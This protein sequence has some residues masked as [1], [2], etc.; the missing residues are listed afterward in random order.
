MRAFQILKTAFVFRNRA[1]NQAFKMSTEAASSATPTNPMEV[2]VKI[3][4]D[5]VWPFCFIGLRNLEAASKQSGVPTNLA[6]EP[7][8]LNPNMPPEGESIKEHMS[9]KYGPSAVKNLGD[10][11]SGLAR[12]GA[13]VGI[14]FN[15]ERNI[16]PTVQAHS[17]LE[18]VKN[19]LGD[20]KKANDM[21]EELYQRYFIQ[22]QNINSVPVL[23]EVC[24]MFGI[25]DKE[26]VKAVA[27]DPAR[28]QKVFDKDRL[29]KTRMNIHG[30]PFFIIEPNDGGTPT[31]FSGAQP[32]DLM[33]EYLREAAGIEE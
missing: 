21:M 9:K 19:E 11:S 32:P 23:Q 30:V 33:A 6:W 15:N 22:A 26:L 27:E 3:V 29:F 7:F 28:H 16:Y 2:T 1:L 14:E 20:T 25:T 5:V 24:E 18:Y 10:K 31:G 17:V 8:M 4:S 12:A 13:A